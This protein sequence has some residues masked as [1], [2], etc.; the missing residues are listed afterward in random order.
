MYITPNTWTNVSGKMHQGNSYK[1]LGSQH[2]KY[3]HERTSYIGKEFLSKFR[4]L[5][6]WH[7]LNV[8]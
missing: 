7:V 1:V 4:L 5:F 3:K 2:S 8:A 6:G